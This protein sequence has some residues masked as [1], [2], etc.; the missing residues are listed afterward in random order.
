[1]D[2][3]NRRL[4]DDSVIL[5]SQQYSQK[6]ED[7]KTVEFSNV[8]YRAMKSPDFSTSLDALK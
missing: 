3:I 7:W 5:D 4:G 6:D 1:M 8:I 2:K